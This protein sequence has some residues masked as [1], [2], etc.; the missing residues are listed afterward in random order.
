VL[1]AAGLGGLSLA[2]PFPNPCN[3][4]ADIVVQGRPGAEVSISVHDLRGGRLAVQRLRLAA[5]G[6]AVW[7]F[8]GRD[9]Q[10][11]S[12]AA[13]VYRIVAQSEAGFA[14]RSVTLVK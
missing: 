13:G 2:D 11:H 12:L 8:A 7:T 3:P 1:P 5:D 9:A 4:R 10:G 6:T 14:A